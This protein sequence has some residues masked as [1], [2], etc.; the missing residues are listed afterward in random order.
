MNCLELIDL[1]ITPNKFYQYN[2]PNKI[3]IISESE[4][5]CG[6]INQYVSKF[7]TLE[8]EIQRLM[9]FFCNFD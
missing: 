9:Q 1:V 4:Q 8:E 7:G 3:E 6:L 5:M 2:K